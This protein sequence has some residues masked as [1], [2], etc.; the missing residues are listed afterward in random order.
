MELYQ[1]ECFLTLSQFQNVSM[2]AE[3]LNISQPSLSKTIA[4]LEAE[5]GV[6][7]FDRVGRRIVLNSHGRMF[8][9][10]AGNVLETLKEGTDSVRKME[11]C[12]SG[13]ISIGLFVYTGL[14]SECLHV[15]LQQYPLVKMSLYSSKSQYTIDNFETLDFVLTSALT[16]TSPGR[17][18]YLESIPVEE[19]DYV[20]LA[21]PELLEQYLPGTDTENVSLAVFREVPFIA[22][23]DNLLFSDI[24]HLFCQQSGFTPK[25]V[26]Q[27]NDYATK[28][29]MTALGT[30]AAFLPEICVPVFKSYRKDLVVVH[31]RNLNSTRTIYLSRRKTSMTSQTCDIFWSFAKKYYLPG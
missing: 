3:R 8:A 9:H 18:D 4:L 14:L 20:L 28:L 12:P 1:L 13:S 2:A 24:T 22:M 16:T 10:Y 6:K 5:L 26:I 23:A 29:H 30:G 21:A 31:P 7:L 17:N 19:E 15:F 11:I 25:I 27:T